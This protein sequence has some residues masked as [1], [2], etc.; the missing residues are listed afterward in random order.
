MISLIKSIVG[1]ISAVFTFFIN[2]LISF[3]QFIRLIPSIINSL[4]SILVIFPQF[5]LVYIGFGITVTV[6]L[7]LINRKADS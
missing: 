3:F 5:S 7:F 6:L 1:A 4:S 2:L